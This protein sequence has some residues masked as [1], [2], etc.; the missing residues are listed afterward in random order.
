MCIRTSLEDREPSISLG[1]SFTEMV[2]AIIKEDSFKNT[3]PEYKAAY[4]AV[5]RITQYIQ[6]VSE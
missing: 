3:F 6:L 5:A 2:K 4:R 1:F